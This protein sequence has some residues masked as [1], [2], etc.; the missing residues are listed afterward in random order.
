MQGQMPKIT[1]AELNGVWELAKKIEREKRRLEDLRI[2]AAGTTPIL[3]GM[4]HTQPIDFKVERLA[5]M[6]SDTE[7]LI[8]ALLKQLADLKFALLMK[9]Q[10]F[11]LDELQERV[12]TYHY[13]SC[14]KFKEIAKLMSYTKEYVSMLHSKGLKALGLSTSTMTAVRKDISFNRI[15]TAYYLHLTAFKL[16]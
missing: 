6:M 7:S 5:T 10:S 12:L 11:G 15:L 13:V 4:P 9:L 2:L 8:R 3:D 14:L 16:V 1:C